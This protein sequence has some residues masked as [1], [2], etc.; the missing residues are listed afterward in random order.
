MEQHHKTSQ[1]PS[2]W[3]LTPSVTISSSSLDL[4]EDKM[5]LSL[6]LS[7]LSTPVFLLALCPFHIR[8]EGNKKKVFHSSNFSKP[9]LITVSSYRP[10]SIRALRSSIHQ[11]SQVRLVVAASI[12]ATEDCVWA[13]AGG[14]YPEHLLL[15]SLM[16]IIST[17]NSISDLSCLPVWIQI[18]LATN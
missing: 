6:C 3:I 10:S 14:P 11:T 15:N 16:K 1:N 8:E 5:C 12:V 18:N 9:L 17:S 4:A 7:V 13:R 2:P